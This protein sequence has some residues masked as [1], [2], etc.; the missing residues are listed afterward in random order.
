MFSFPKRRKALANK[1]TYGRLE[2]HFDGNSVKPNGPSRLLEL[3]DRYSIAIAES[4]M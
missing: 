2:Q 3:A 4:E 1:S